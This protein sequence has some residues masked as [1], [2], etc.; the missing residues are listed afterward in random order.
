MT[1]TKRLFAG[2]EI[3]GIIRLNIYKL[4]VYFHKKWKVEAILLDSKNVFLMHF[5]LH[6]STS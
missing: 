1:S 6:F 4:K 2:S 3:N 5:C